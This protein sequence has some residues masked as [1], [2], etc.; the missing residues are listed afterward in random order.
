MQDFISGF[1]KAAALKEVAVVG[2]FH[3]GK[4]LMGKRRDNAKWT[5]PGGHLEDGEKPLLGAVRELHEE[6]GIKADPSDLEHL[7]SKLVTKS[8]GEKMKVH[9][10]KLDLLGKPAT[11]M[12]NDP[13]NEVHRWHWTDINNPPKEVF[14][15]LHVPLKDNVL[16]EALGVKDFFKRLGYSDLYTDKAKAGRA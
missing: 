14:S 3:N 11:S 2:V 9:A 1:Y 5:Q 7:K 6:A 8:D 10:F 15:A 12:R 13:D 16:L 4:M